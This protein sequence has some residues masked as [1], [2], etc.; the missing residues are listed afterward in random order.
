MVFGDLPLGAVGT[1]G[2]VEGIDAHGILS[3]FLKLVRIDVYILFP[4][5]KSSLHFD[6]SFSSSKFSLSFPSLAPIERVAD[7]S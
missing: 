6:H 2:V 3:T 7:V 5:R 4:C 1:D